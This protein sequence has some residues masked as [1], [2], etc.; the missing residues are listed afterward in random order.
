MPVQRPS[1]SL[2]EARHVMDRILQEAG[3]TPQQQPIAVAICDEQG[4]LVAFARQDLC[5]PQPLQIARKKA[6]TA[7]RTGQDTRAY[8]ER[9]RQQNRLVTEF[10]DPNLV[11]LQGGLAILDP[12]TQQP[13]GGVGVSG[14]T[15]E[16]D[17]QLARLGLETLQQRR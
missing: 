17:E 13:V 12:S 8:A 14:R 11:A 9:L 3:R 5:R 10:G 16:E 7:A 4:E 15:A 1:I 2:D 6:Y